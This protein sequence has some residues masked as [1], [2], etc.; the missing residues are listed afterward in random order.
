MTTCPEC[1]SPISESA[2]ACPHCGRPLA[3][4]VRAVVSGRWLAAA[5][6]LMVLLYV[7]STAATLFLYVGFYLL[8]GLV[9]YT[10]YWFIARRIRRR[11][12]A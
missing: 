6:G 4:G 11:R 9:L 7:L 3:A 8:V 1:T 2:R 12:L 5:W 10:P